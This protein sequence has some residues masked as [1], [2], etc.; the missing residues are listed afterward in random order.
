MKA[1]HRTADLIIIVAVVLL[2]AMSIL[3]IFSASFFK[4]EQ[5]RG[6]RYHYLKRQ[7]LWVGVG[8][9][10]MF[11]F[12]QIQYWHW[13][14]IARPLLLITFLMLVLVLIPGIGIWADG[15]RR[16]LGVGPLAFQPSEAAKL[17]LVIFWAALFS[18]RKE[19]VEK[20]W[21]ILPAFLGIVGGVAVLVIQQP[22]LGTTITI[23]A[24]SVVMLF[25]AGV[26]FRY[27]AFLGALAA[28]A[29]AWLVLSKGTRMRRIFAFLNPQDDP[30]GAGH[31]IIQS[32]YALGSGHLFGV[33]YGAG[34]QK[35]YYLPAEHTDFIFAI[36]G[37]ELGFLGAGAIL[38]LFIVIGWRG[39]RV[40]VNAPDSF[41]SLLGVG[42]VSMVV[43]QAA[44][45]IGVVTATLPVTG[46]PLP[47]ISYG[48]SSLVFTLAGLGMLLNL[49]K[50]VPP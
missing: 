22:D 5:E 12:A 28:P 24:T 39:Y 9:V 44:I 41:G 2:L 10:V 23:A 1:R 11:G 47:L 17:V 40:A 4:A 34:R 33:G 18:Q 49:S 48:G 36:V 35:F 50:Y 32:L 3:M 37:E 29:L 16:W 14:S 31:Q 8:L 21:P 27:L 38:L 15:S 26:R 45:N 43:L 20:F 13:R 30:L 42:L 6:D 7:L 46:I 19:D 25:V